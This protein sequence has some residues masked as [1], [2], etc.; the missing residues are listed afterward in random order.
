MSAATYTHGASHLSQWESCPGSASAQIGLPDE[1]SKDA[2]EGTSLHSHDADPSLDRSGL[3]G[4]QLDVLKYAA[5]GDELIF[6]SVR[7]SLSIGEDEPFEEGRED[8]RWFRRGIKALFPGHNDRW[9][10]Y[11]ARK[12]LVIIDKKFGRIEVDAADANRQLMAYG[13]MGADEMDPD[14]VLVA[15][16]Q[17]RLPYNQRLTIGEYN[18]ESLA[19]AKAL[20]LSIWDG[21]HNKDGSPREDVP[22]VAGES[23]CRYCKARLNC[24]AFRA[25]Y[26]FLAKPSADGKDAFVARLE[27][28]TDEELD[29]V[30]IACRFAALI[31]D[32]AKK[33]IIARIEGGRMGHYELKPGNKN[34]KITDVPLAVKLLNGLGLSTDAIL[35]RCKISLDDVSEDVRTARGITQKEAKL[36][37][38]EAVS[39]VLEI[40]QNA[41]SLK[42]TGETQGKLA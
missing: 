37:V 25:K 29:K 22:R 13:I 6:A 1:D 42:R 39:T 5:E 24:D 16:N 40:G 23:Q 11:P 34:S 41:P 38:K 17:P 10:F 21:S 4:E 30:F 8:E 14:H 26:E 3:T 2:Q 15:I 33:E 35:R 27:Q 28:L 20:L 18:R 36:M 12:V 7:S 9:R 32:S 19:K 31:S